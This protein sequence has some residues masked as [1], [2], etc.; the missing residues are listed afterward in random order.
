MPFKNNTNGLNTPGDRKGG[1]QKDANRLFVLFGY[2]I[3]SKANFKFFTIFFV[4]QLYFVLKY[5]IDWYEI[6]FKI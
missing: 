4:N 6:H 2:G 1:L 5:Y 3:L